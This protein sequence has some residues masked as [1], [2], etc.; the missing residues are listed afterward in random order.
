MR[1]LERVF[2]VTVFVIAG[3]MVLG[4]GFFWR[5]ALADNFTRTQTYTLYKHLTPPPLGPRFCPVVDTGTYCL[6]ASASQWLAAGP[7]N[8]TLTHNSTY[9]ELCHDPH[10]QPVPPDPGFAGGDAGEA[11]DLAPWL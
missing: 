9:V 7:S 10:A 6:V 2:Q 1:I 5:E 8:K 3:F 4:G 11:A